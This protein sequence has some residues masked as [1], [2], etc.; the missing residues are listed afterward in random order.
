MHNVRRYVSPVTVLGVAGLLRRG[1]F[2]G[3]P[4][5][6]QLEEVVALLVEAE[7]VRR[8]HVE[9]RDAELVDEVEGLHKGKRATWHMRGCRR[10]SMC[11]KM[12]C[13]ARQR[14]GER[15]IQREM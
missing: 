6:A 2:G 1:E 15:E 14:E 8:L 13:F 7:K 10:E 4:E 9:V 3:Q 5:V 11:S 12:M